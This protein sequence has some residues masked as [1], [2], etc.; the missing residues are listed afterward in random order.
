LRGDGIDLVPPEGLSMKGLAVRV[1][2]VLPQAK[3]LNVGDHL[4]VTI[5]GWGKA[6]VLGGAD[7]ASVVNPALVPPPPDGFQLEQ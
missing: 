5:P 1:R 4:H 7:R 2:K 3:I 6:P